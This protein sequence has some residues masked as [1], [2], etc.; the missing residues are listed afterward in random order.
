MSYHPSLTDYIPLGDVRIL[1]FEPP[2]APFF[3]STSECGAE[4]NGRFKLCVGD[5]NTTV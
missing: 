5:W 1:D 2:P 3:I 4:G